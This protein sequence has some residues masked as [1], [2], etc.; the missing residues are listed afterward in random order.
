MQKL[1]GRQDFKIKWPNDILYRGKKIS[2]IL[3]EMSLD[4]EGKIDYVIVGI[5]IN[6]NM[7]FANYSDQLSSIA[8][9]LH[10]ITGSEYERENVLE[11]FLKE[12]MKLYK[13]W[14][15]EGFTKIRQAWLE[16]NCTLGREVVVKDED[17]EIFAGIAESLYDDGSLCIKNATGV[18]ERFDFGELSVRTV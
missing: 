3:S 2:G 9:S 16:N 8:T 12:F 13:C 4:T 18:V 15:N 5:G 6:V 1:T 7:H 11:S 10:L 14:H 17:Q